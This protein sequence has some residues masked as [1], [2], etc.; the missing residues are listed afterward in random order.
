[1]Q[2]FIANEQQQNWL[3]ANP[4]PNPPNEM[5]PTD[6]CHKLWSES[7]R[8]TRQHCMRKPRDWKRQMTKIYPWP[9]HNEASWIS[10]KSTFTQARGQ[11]VRLSP[12]IRR[13][14]PCP[15]SL[16]TNSPS[17]MSHPRLSGEEYG[18]LLLKQFFQ[19]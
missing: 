7:Q 1:M 14:V 4:R 10:P 17:F 12:S 8:N 3:L 18:C 6:L 15:T 2:Y 16:S 9:T 19:I 11:A 5:N 13:D